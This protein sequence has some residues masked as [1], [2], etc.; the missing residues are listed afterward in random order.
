MG[1][2]AGAVTALAPGLDQLFR[3]LGCVH[4]AS[5]ATLPPLPGEPDGT[6][7]S[8]MLELAVD[9]GIGTSLLLELLVARGQAVLWTLYRCCVTGADPPP[10][11]ARAAWLLALLRRDVNGAAG[12][13][14]GARDRTVRQILR[15]R[16]LYLQA[17]NHAAMLKA[18]RRIESDW[19]AREMQQWASA[20]RD[21]DWA[22]RPAPRSFWRTRGPRRLVAGL[23][24]ALTL[25]LAGTAAARVLEPLALAWFWRWPALLLLTLLIIVVGAILVA[26]L[27]PLWLSLFTVL[28]KSWR[29]AGRALAR[30]HRHRHAM[31][32]H[33]VPRAQQV[34]PLVQACEAAL[35]GGPNHVISLTELR[36]PARW[37]R[38]WL[39]W[40][41]AFFTWL[42]RWIFVRGRL[43]DASGVKYGHWHLIDKGRRLLFCSNY[44]GSFGGYLDEF[45]LGAT[46]GVNLFWRRTRMKRRVAAAPGQ[47]EVKHDRDFPPTRWWSMHGG[48]EYEQWF[49]SYARDSMLPHLYIFQAYT[50]SH[51]EI[52]RATGL[53]DALFGPRNAVNDDII[54]RA[55]ES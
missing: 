23:V 16:A 40:W 14:V 47:P 29:A 46:W 13:Y 10:G 6:T 19:L 11:E 34:H 31:N 15:E 9:E 49:K 20:T 50:H 21:F 28:R 45:I 39:R 5:I 30:W 17:R 42:G 37:H 32:P 2:A 48:C 8:L 53:R 51:D 35:V 12:G 43:G 4:F 1:G 7:P 52:E 44:D 22:W 41:L 3:Q 18:G 27:A 38:G 36:Q 55:L 54:A 33:E 24:G 25:L 26:L